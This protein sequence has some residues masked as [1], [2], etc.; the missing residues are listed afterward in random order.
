YTNLFLERM[1][2]MAVRS[3]GTKILIGSQAISDLTA[4]NAPQ[5]TAETIDVTTL[6]SEGGYR[7]SIAGF[8]DSGE[9]TLTGHFNSASLGQRALDAAFESGDEQT[10]TIVYPRKTGATQSFR[11]VVSAIGGTN[12]EVDGVIGY[13]ATIKVNGPAPIIYDV[14][15]GLSALS[16]SGTGGT[17]SPPF[18][19][20]IDKYAFAG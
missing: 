6:E 10:F 12:A 18:A 15:D 7:E 1:L 13:E 14:S 5:R 8:K 3:L 20:S 9:V 4:I 11:G 16:L 19:S 17:L 2:E